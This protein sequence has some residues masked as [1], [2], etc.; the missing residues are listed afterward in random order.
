MKQFADDTI[1]AIA[2][3]IGIGG[4]GIVRISGDGAKPLLEKIY[5]PSCEQ[6]IKSH[7]MLHGLLVDPDNG[8]H[9]DEA[10][11]CYM[12]SPKSFTGEDVAEIYCHGGQAVLQQVL[13]LVLAQGARLAQ[14]GEFTKRAFLNK[15]L[16]LSQSEAVLALIQA[17]T[18]KGAGFALQQLEGRLSKTVNNLRLR[19]VNL[20]AELEGALDFSDDLPPLD[21]SRFQLGINAIISEVSQL[22][23]SAS[24]GKIYREGL[25]TAIIGKPNVG[26]SSL[27]NAFLK[28]ERAIVT[29]VPGTTRD[30]IE[31]LININGL[32]LRIIDTAGLRQTKDRLEG[33]GIERTEKE[34]AAADFV[35]IVLDRSQEIDALDKMVLDKARG[36]P[37]VVVLNKS[38]LPKRLNDKGLGKI[39]FDVS[40]LTGAGVHELSL[41]IFNEVQKNLGQE[42]SSSVIINSRH[43]ECLS[44]AQG[45]LVKSAETVS[46]KL[47]PEFIAVDLKESIVALGEVTGEIVSDEIINTI[48]DQFCI[49]K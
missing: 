7:Q 33:S 40:A 8:K 46:K 29:D 43:K 11:A 2:T 19:L 16:D 5:K 1:T 9:I 28:E 36:K 23:A 15:K 32:P 21:Y 13:A 20:Q 37:G 10:M 4:V 35:L 47:S 41:G 26:K 42:S 3:P 22:L 44:R 49:G 24:S 30:A 38:D 27:L 31:E 18:A 12:Q 48:F 34:L 45:S 14:R 17:P 25:S 6:E 39:F